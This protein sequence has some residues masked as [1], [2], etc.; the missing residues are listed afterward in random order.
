MGTVKEKSSENL[1]QLCSQSES[2]EMVNCSKT[3]VGS[4]N[5][6]AMVGPHKRKEW[7][8]GFESLPGPRAWVAEWLIAVLW[9]L[10]LA[11]IRLDE[12]PIL[13]IGKSLITASGFESLSLRNVYYW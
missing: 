12:E 5:K 13:K 3:D 8:R 1:H 7:V 6:D 10:F 4:F 11:R 9:H 2:S